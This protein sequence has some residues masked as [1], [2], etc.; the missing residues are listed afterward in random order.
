MDVRVGSFIYALGS[1]Y[2]RSLSDSFTAV[3]TNS[4]TVLHSF[5]SL[6]LCSKHIYC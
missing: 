3:I 5:C 4:S 6:I 1:Y 2:S